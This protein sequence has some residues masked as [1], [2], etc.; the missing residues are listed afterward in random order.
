MEQ[1]NADCMMPIAWKLQAPVIALSS[2][3]M[4]PWHYDRVGQ[5]LIPSYVPALFMG[6]SDEMTFTQRLNNW[7][8]VY[9]LKF[10]YK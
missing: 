3:A 2:C 5:P 4:M 6:Y 10:L 7:I 9:G 1:F 8:A